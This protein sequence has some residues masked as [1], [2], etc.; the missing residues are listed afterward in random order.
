MENSIANRQKWTALLCPVCVKPLFPAA[1]SAEEKCRSVG[2]ESGHSFDLSKEGY[3]NLLLGS[4]G[5]HGDDKE[6]IRARHRFLSGGTYEPLREKI[7]AALDTAKP[8]VL[9]DAG[10]GEGYYTAE[11]AKHAKNTVGIDL[12]KEALRLAAKRPESENIAYACA[13]VYKLP[14]PDRSVDTVLSVFSPFAAGEFLRVLSENGNAVYVYPG[15]KH[16]WELK[17]L[18]YQTPYENEP[19]EDPPAGFSLIDTFAVDYRAELDQSRIADLFT[20]TP[21]FYRTPKEGREKLLA[22]EKLP[23]TVSFGIMLLRKN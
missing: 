15:R 11:A 23:L 3:L 16:L 18:L 12:S 5:T 17:E 20:M 13:S 19:Q 4:G 14:L 21:Y 8:G 2:C 7:C 1:S 9:L 6:M 10:C 22:L